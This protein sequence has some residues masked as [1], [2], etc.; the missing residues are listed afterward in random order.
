M[1]GEHLPRIGERGAVLDS[2]G[3]F[4]FVIET[5]G[6]DVVRLR[7][8]PDAHA[9]DEGEGYASALE[10][11]EGHE[12]FWRSPEMSNELGPDFSLDDGTF[13]VLERF[14]VVD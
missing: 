1:T 7:D 11:R 5:T 10:W 2:T 9:R 13:V 14:R 4:A 3:S 12:R 8:V 6:V